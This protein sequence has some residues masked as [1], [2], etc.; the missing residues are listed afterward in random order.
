MSRGYL[1]GGY[2]ARGVIVRWVF[3]RW[4]FV[5]WVFVL[6]SRNLCRQDPVTIPG[7]PVIFRNHA[8]YPTKVGDLQKIE[9]KLSPLSWSHRRCQLLLLA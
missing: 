4:V 7:T 8:K 3:V 1:S 2:L 6:E 5:R 9:E